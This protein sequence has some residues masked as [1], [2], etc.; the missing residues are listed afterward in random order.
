MRNNHKKMAIVIVA[1]IAISMIAPSFVLLFSNANN[2]SAVYS[3]GTSNSNGN[4]AT[5]Q[6]LQSQVNTL[7]QALQSNPQDTTTR[8]SLANAYYDLAVATQSGNT[9]ADAGPIFKQAVAEY[10]EV[11]KT[12]KDVN[13]LV[14]MATAAFYGGEDEIADKTF[15]EALAIKPDFLNALTNYGFFLMEAK[16]DYMGAI[17]QWD[18]ALAKSSPS[19]EE[20]GRLNG[21]IKMAQERLKSSFEQSGSINNPGSSSPSGAK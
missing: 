3:K 8:L 12:Q 1:L 14:D 13:I 5:V 17:A 4:N 19:P 2:S 16:N 9:S 18:T 10:Q 21:F 6:G 11:T 20:T 15:K 7:S